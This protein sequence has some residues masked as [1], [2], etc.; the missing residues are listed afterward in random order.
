MELSD[1]TQKNQELLSDAQ[2]VSLAS[3]PHV[4]EQELPTPRGGEFRNTLEDSTEVWLNADSR[5]TYP[6]T[7]DG[8]Q[9]RVTLEGEAYFKVAKD[10]TK[11]FVVVSGSQ[12]VRV[13]GT[14][15]NVCAYSDEKDI[16][17][18]LVE[19]SI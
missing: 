16:R 19:G 7:F 18:T 10:A 2:S 11:P 5:L 13:Y 3:T 14:E 4:S 12:E 6:E 15:F 8:S 17:T 9:R 1:D